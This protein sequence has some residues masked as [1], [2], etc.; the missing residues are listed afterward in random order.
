MRNRPPLPVRP[1]HPLAP[2]SA[3]PEP[4][5]PTLNLLGTGEPFWPTIEIDWSGPLTGEPLD[6]ERS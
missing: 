1:V 6:S 2:P 5:S 4:G 3:P